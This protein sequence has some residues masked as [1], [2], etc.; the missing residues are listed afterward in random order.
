MCGQ[1]GLAQP[2][3][4]TY[5]QG[6]DCIGR[7]TKNRGNLSGRELIDLGMP[8]HSLPSLRE[9][10]E[11]LDDYC[12]FG[13]FEHIIRVGVFGVELRNVI[14]NDAFRCGLVP[15]ESFPGDRGQ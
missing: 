2:F 5:R 12:R 11:R 8:Q 13:A 7:H 4:G 1:V 9:G 15:G 14:G 10:F 6:R 3:T